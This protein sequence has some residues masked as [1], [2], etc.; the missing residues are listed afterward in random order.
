MTTF[1]AANPAIAARLQRL[2]PIMRRRLAGVSYLDTCQVL[3]LSRVSDNAGGT[4]DEWVLSGAPIPCRVAPGFVPP[5]EAVSLARLV[6][7][8]AW[9]VYIHPDADVRADD[10]LAVTTSRGGYAL[11]VTG[12][13]APRT[14][15]LEQV[16][17]AQ[18]ID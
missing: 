18:E 8:S 14:I 15:D 9:L 1:P 16:I 7:V 3:R 10:T 5:R 12:I 6:A 2:A 4:H 17:E 11:H 13:R